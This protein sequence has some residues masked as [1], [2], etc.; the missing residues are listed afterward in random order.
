[1]G[2]IWTTIKIVWGAIETVRLI[3]SLIGADVVHAI[4]QVVIFCVKTSALIVHFIVD[5]AIHIIMLDFQ[6]ISDDLSRFGKA[7][8]NLSESFLKDMIAT[9]KAIKI[10]FKTFLEVIHFKYIRVIHTILLFTHENYRIAVAEF[11]GSVVKIS[12]SLGEAGN[13]LPMLL[14]IVQSSQ[15]TFC[16]M[17]GEN[18]ETSHLRWIK[19]VSA[20]D[21]WD[22]MTWRGKKMSFVEMCDWIDGAHQEIFPYGGMNQEQIDYLYGPG[23]VL[24]GKPH[25]Y[26]GELKKY[27]LSLNPDIFDGM[28]NISKILIGQTEAQLEIAEATVQKIYKM[29]KKID[30]S[31]LSLGFGLGDILEKNVEPL[32]KEVKHFIGYVYEPAIGT[33]LEMIK[34]QKREMLLIEDQIRE[35]TEKMIKPGNLL[36]S[37]DHLSDLERLDQEY[38]IA[39]VSS[40]AENREAI[41]INEDVDLEA[42]RIQEEWGKI[43]T[44][45]PLPPYT[46]KEAEGLIIQRGEEPRAGQ[47]WYVGDF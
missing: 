19:R 37:V 18:Y 46:V 24:K 29:D 47:S 25:P 45:L 1:M 16:A 13:T 12:R 30:R 39:E 43:T 36:T 8:G 7:L 21:G 6:D 5:T 34:K 14:R 35:N 3:I 23:G 26:I 27:N 28:S 41:E 20:W 11:W 9:I 31:V 33:I 38:K 40:R 22:A 17:M 15:Q 42:L 2:V 10:N 44:S 4:I 32:R